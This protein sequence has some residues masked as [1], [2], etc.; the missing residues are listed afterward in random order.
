MGNQHT[1]LLGSFIYA[2]FT[3]LTFILKTKFYIAVGSFGWLLTFV[4]GFFILAPSTDDGYYVIA[5]LGTA[6]KGSPGFWIGDEFAASFF[7]PTGFTFVYGVVLKLTMV[8]GLDFGPFGFRVYQFLFILA[9]PL[10]VLIALRQIFP[11]DYALRFLVRG[12]YR[13]P[14]TYGLLE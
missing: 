11:R 9:L 7:L 2:L 5:S 3:T 12:G 14:F 1:N 4:I 13:R 6:L 8:M 10:F